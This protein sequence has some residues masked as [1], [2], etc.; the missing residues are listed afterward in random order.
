MKPRIGLPALDCHAHVAPDVT[1]AQLQT[2]G[3]AHIFAV[4]RSLDE[5]THVA[6]RR[7][8][9]LTWGIG[10]HPAVPDAQSAFSVDDFRSLVGRFALVG[11]VGLDRRVGGERQVQVLTDVMTA[12][13]DESVLISIHS[14]G[15]V[16][17]TLDILERHPHP[18]IIF[19]WFLGGADE[20]TRAVETGAYFSVN[21]AMSDEMIMSLPL[22][23]ILPETDFP[24]RKARATKP[25]DVSPLEVRLETLWDMPI[26]FVRQ[27][28]WRNLRQVSLQSGAIDRFSE[29][30]ADLV[31]SA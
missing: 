20:C 28:M 4:T 25:G 6:T 31:L 9:N 27:R 13:R 16:T 10:V 2:L 17:Q 30:L 12:C 24:A 3:D 29:N 18:G 7:D 26:D 8:P 19:H 14:T 21:A 5:A 15:R 11:E 1:T 22:E 23:R